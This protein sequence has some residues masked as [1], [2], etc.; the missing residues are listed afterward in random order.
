VGDVPYRPATAE[1]D[2]DAEVWTITASAGRGC[3]LPEAYNRRSAFRMLS[4]S[5]AVVVA[6]LLAGVVA[7]VRAG[8]DRPA[9][10]TFR[11]GV[12]AVEVS[13]YV[14]DRDGNPVADLTADDFEL[15][16]DGVPQDVTSFALVDIPVE[17]FERPLFATRD[18]EP[19]VATNAGPEGRLYVFL[20]DEVLPAA[21]LRIRH[22]L[23]PFFEREFGA[24][25]V[26]ALVYLGRGQSR[27]T[28]GFTGSRRLL[29]E[30]V[31][32]IQPGF[33]DLFGGPA[34]DAEPTSTRLRVGVL[35]QEESWLMRA[36]MR[37]LREL[38]ESMAE[39]PGR[40]KALLYFTHGIGM[41]VFDVL[42]YSGGAKSVAFDD[43][44]R[45]IAAATR[46]GVAFYPIDP[47]GLAALDGCS[48]A[49]MAETMELRA[50]AEATGGFAVRNTNSFADNFTQIVRE[51]SKYYLLGFSS[52]NER[53][54]GRFREIDVRVRRPGLEVRTREGYLEPKGR[55]DDEDE[56]F[57]TLPV[58]VA[59]AL[60]S[61]LPDRSVP[62]RV[63]AVPFRGPGRD[64]NV[65]L[66]LEL[67]AASLGFVEQAGVFT[68]EIALATLAVEADGDVHPGQRYEALVELSPDRHRFAEAG[69]VRMLTEM[70]L[71]AGR[72]QL[73]LVA[74]SKAR[75]GSVVVDLDVPDF[76]KGPLV[77]SGVALTA[78]SAGQRYTVPH[79]DHLGPLMPGPL[80]AAREFAA[81]DEVSVYAEV[82]ENGRRA[83]H[84]VDVRVELRSDTG[85]VL[86]TSTEARASGALSRR[87]EDNGFTASL[88]L[89][90]EPGL[91]VIHVE[92]RAN[93]DDRPTVGRDVLIRVR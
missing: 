74:G 50:L 75:A 35:N 59:D 29:L 68:A 11:A 3:A 22:L 44:H 5:R 78:A 2:D 28:Q 12:E 49:N 60:R 4:H 36:R 54:D 18:I 64:A 48:T 76:T 1:D 53:R 66:V 6:V 33:Q 39:I 51:N 31:N 14:T 69:G 24:N 70:Q 88:P 83:A 65:A 82:Y 72:Y 58:A 67:D 89:D 57:T 43:L 32:R 46:G 47:C 92:A 10:P 85:A 27:N 9:Q 86:R 84:T 45:V 87:G 20:I 34:E 63:S 56:R 91:Y 52:T 55:A 79:V 26:A 16:E 17:P 90:V 23:Q 13:V 21:A 73:R 62:L 61:P 93:I 19:D 40:R 37:S 81:G 80:T 25:D 7:A 30:A 77:M 41:D 71:P 38:V 42:D 8:Q 15:L